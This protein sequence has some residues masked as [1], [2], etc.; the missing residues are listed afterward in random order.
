MEAIG[1]DLCRAAYCC[2]CVI[3]ECEHDQIKGRECRWNKT[4]LH[5]QE[6]GSLYT[7]VFQTAWSCIAFC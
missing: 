2:L 7:K 4:K 5:E 6:H 3:Q 1:S